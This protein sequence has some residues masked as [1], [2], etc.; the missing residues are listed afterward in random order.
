VLS[1]TGQGILGYDDQTVYEGEFVDGLRN[2]QGTMVYGNG[3]IYE[4][5][6]VNGQRTGPDG[7]ATE[8]IYVAH[9]G[10]EIYQGEFVDN[11]RH[12]SG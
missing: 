1:H 6:W 7:Q 3:D 4:G 8:G 9:E 11:K 12:G 2:G 10:K 5:G